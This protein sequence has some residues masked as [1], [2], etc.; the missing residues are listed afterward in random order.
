MPMSFVVVDG[1]EDIAW[2]MATFGRDYTRPLAEIRAREMDSDVPIHSKGEAM[3]GWDAWVDGRVAVV[4]ASLFASPERRRTGAWDTQCY[5]NLAQ[6]RMLYSRQADLYHRLVEQ[7]ADKFRL[8]ASRQ[9]I[10]DVLRGWEGDPPFSPRLGLVMAMEG[11]DAIE[12]PPEIE[13]WYKRGVRVVGPAWTGTRYAGGT[14]EPGPFTREGF[15]LMDGLAEWGILLDVS[16]LTDEGVLQALDHYAGPIAASHCTARALLPNSLL[17]ERHLTDEAL[18]GIAARGGLVGVVLGNKFLKDGWQD[19]DPRTEVTLDYVAVHVD[20][21]CQLVGSADH[22]GLGSDLDG[23]IG[24]RSVPRDL[25]SVA[26]LQ[27]IAGVLQARGYDDGSVAKVLGGNWLRLL[28]Q[29]LPET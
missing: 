7:H 29:A 14:Y 9:D 27:Q 23:G 6:A 25:D 22:V 11:A 28:R 13:S 20:Y 10:E 1:H 4:L 17:P 18:Q 26:D 21:I 2:N 5:A 12:S 24:L 8:I 16:H 15:A 19:G 3:L